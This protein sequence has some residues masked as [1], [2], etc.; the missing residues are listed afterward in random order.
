MNVNGIIER[1]AATGEPVQIETRQGEVL[2]LSRVCRGSRFANVVPM[3]S[4]M[5]VD[6]EDLVS[7]D[8]SVESGGSAEP[9][10]T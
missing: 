6:P 10:P 5:V 3:P 1:V 4:L 9:F 7:T 2:Q 8:W